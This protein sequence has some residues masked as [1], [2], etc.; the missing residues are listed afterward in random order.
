[1][2]MLSFSYEKYGFN[3]HLTQMRGLYLKHCSLELFIEKWKALAE[4]CQNSDFC[5]LEKYVFKLSKAAKIKPK[6]LERSGFFL[7]VPNRQI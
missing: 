6:H 5:F 2:P 7:L 1:M 4:N 3:Y